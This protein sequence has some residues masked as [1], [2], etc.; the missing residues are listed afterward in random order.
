MDFKENLSSGFQSFHAI[1]MT[2]SFQSLIFLIGWLVPSAFQQLAAAQ[3]A[4]LMDVYT[5]MGESPFQPTQSVEFS[6]LTS[7]RFVQIVDNR[8]QHIYMSSICRQCGL[9]RTDC[10]QR[11]QCCPNVRFFPFAFFF[12]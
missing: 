1:K 9:S 12:H 7:L 3:H 5:A 10:V 11:Q 2:F 6:I 8:M 4:A